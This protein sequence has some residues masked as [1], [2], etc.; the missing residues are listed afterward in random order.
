MGQSVDTRFHFPPSNVDITCNVSVIDLHQT[1]Y[2]LPKT[3]NAVLPSTMTPV[4]VTPF[5]IINVWESLFH[6][7]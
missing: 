2:F 5:T 4:R 7:Q 3:F 6:Q 1:N